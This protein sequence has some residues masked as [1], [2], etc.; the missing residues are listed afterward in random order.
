MHS[1]ESS[2]LVNGVESK[3]GTGESYY[4]LADKGVNEDARLSVG[5]KIVEDIDDKSRDKL[6]KY[7]DE[8]EVE[9]E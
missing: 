3:G 6:L 1:L 7:V 4:L 5:G 2:S 9:E 8:D